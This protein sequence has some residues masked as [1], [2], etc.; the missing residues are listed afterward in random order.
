MTLRKLLEE[1]RQ[2]LQEAGVPEAEENAWY[3]LQACFGKRDFSFRRSDYFLR[4]EEEAEKSV[5]E[6]FRFFLEE[7]KRRVPLEY[8]IGYTEFMGIVFEVDKNVLIP[9]QDTETLV[10]R[11]LPLCEGKRVL[12]LCAGSGCIGL[13]IGVYAKPAEVIMSDVSQ[14]ALQVA[15]RNRRHI[16]ETEQKRLCTD[17]KL[18]CGNLFVPVCGKFDVIVSNPPYIKTEVI[19][20]LMPE[21]RQF[22]PMTALDGGEDGLEFYRRIIKDAPDYLNADGILCFEIGYDQGESVSSLMKERGFTHIQVSKDL[23]GN[24][25]VAMARWCKVPPF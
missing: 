6:R 22:E 13:S 11:M 12:D 3:L 4:R 15:E 23:A 21:V 24:D 20:G 1:G 18:V 5:C 2:E 7:R 16:Q 14:E 25:R 8:I 10:E 17:M 19:S 9:R